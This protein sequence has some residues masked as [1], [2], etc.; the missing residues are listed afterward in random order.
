M[1]LYIPS[2]EAEANLSRVWFGLWAQE[3]IGIEPRGVWINL[4]IV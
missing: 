2:T 1:I 3:S 4:W